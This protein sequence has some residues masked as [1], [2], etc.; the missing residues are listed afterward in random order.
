MCVCLPACLSVS[1]SFFFYLSLCLCVYVYS[2]ACVWVPVS[3]IISKFFII[4]H[5]HNTLNTLSRSIGSFV[6][7]S[8]FRIDYLIAVITGMI[9][10][11]IMIWTHI[12]WL[13]MLSIFRTITSITQ[14]VYSVLLLILNSHEYVLFSFQL[15]FDFT[16]FLTLKNSY[17]RLG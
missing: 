6:A 2:C 12:Q 17:Y 5:N 16:Q 11:L 4:Q 14:T 13:L 7:Y 1:F 9:T 10:C 8:Y 3:P 15:L